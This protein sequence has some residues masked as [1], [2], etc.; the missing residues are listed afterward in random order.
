MSHYLDMWECTF[1]V[2]PDAFGAEVLVC[3]PSSSGEPSTGDSWWTSYA[4]FIA[5]NG[6]MPDQWSCHQEQG[7]GYGSI[8]ES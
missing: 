2:L 5:N 6:S 8:S 1:P 3:G 7:A 4:Q